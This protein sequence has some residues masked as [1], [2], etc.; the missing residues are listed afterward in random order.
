[1]DS[2][3]NTVFAKGRKTGT[4]VLGFIDH[5]DVGR[6]SVCSTVLHSH[7]SHKI[8]WRLSCFVFFCCVSGSLVKVQYK[9]FYRGA[10]VI[11]WQLFDLQPS[12][13]GCNCP[14]STV[15]WATNQPWN[16]F[17]T[18]NIRHCVHLGRHRK[19]TNSKAPDGSMRLRLLDFKTVGT[20]RWYGCQPY[21]S[22]AFTPQEISLVLIS[23]KGW[24]NPRTIV[25]PEGLRQ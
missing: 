4:N 9:L 8:P 10:R 21:S 19:T 18:F 11:W 25:R 14:V 23:V 20:W 3:N 17:W 6:W 5:K 22:A 7:F 24:V 15:I 12:F 1:M 13:Q 16:G 2:G